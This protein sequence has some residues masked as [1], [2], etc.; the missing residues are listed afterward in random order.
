MVNSTYSRNSKHTFSRTEQFGFLLLQFKSVDDQ[1]LLLFDNGSDNLGCNG[2]KI[3]IHVSRHWSTDS[4]CV[5]ST[6][7]QR[8]I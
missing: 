6:I 8:T 3:S 1:H 7:F 5:Y 4:S 2:M